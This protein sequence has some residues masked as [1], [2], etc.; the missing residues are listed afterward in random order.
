MKYI[1][2]LFFVIFSFCSADAATIAAM[3]NNHPITDTDIVSRIKLQNRQGQTAT[4]NRARALDGII[5]DYIKL[6]YAE[7]F[8][9]SP[10]DKEID[11]QLAMMKKNGFNDGGLD[12]ATIAMMRFAIKADIAWQIIIGRTIIP[13]LDVKQEDIDAEIIELER[14]RGLPINMTIVRLTDIPEAE[15]KKLTRAD[16]CDGAVKMAENLGGSPQ[17]FTAVQYELS[18]DIREATAGLPLN[19]WGPRKNGT[20]MLVCAKKKTAEY[21]QLDEII[22]QNAIYKKASFA[23]DQQLKK[24]RR[25]AVIIKN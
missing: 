6:D 9:I 1:Y 11:Q 7:N 25:R 15:Y 5:D 3:A 2:S 24:L 14:N 21:G 10:T 4:D 19:T 13:T 18:A 23:G 8:K 22:K 12:S 17:K 16:S 20:T